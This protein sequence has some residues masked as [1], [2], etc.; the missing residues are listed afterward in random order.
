MKDKGN[1]YKMEPTVKIINKALQRC[2]GQE[3][4]G[5]TM[6]SGIEKRVTNYK[7]KDRRGML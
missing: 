2:L 3:S 4:K 6:L 1:A 7:M 5:N